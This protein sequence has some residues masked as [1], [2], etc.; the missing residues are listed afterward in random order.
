VNILIVSDFHIIEKDID[1]IESIFNE[2]CIIK[3]NNKIDK[4]I[5]AGDTFDKVNPTPKELDCFSKFVKS[6]NIPII[7]LAAQSHE[8][9]SDSISVI[10]HFGILKETIS[11][12][13]EYK[14][15]NHLFVG[16]FTLQESKYHFGSKVSKKSLENYKYV[17]LG[18]QHSLQ[19]IEPNICHVGSIRYIDF[20]E[21]QD[22]NK[23]ALLITDYKTEKQSIKIIPLVTPIHMIDLELSQ[24]LENGRSQAMP[25]LLNVAGKGKESGILGKFEALTDL[26]M[27]LNQLVSKT[28]VRVIFKDYE[29]YKE[30]LPYYEIYKQ[31][32]VLFKD[33]K[34]FIL[35]ISDNTPQSIKTETM[36]ESLI[37]FLEVNKVD[38][39]IK[40]ILEEEINA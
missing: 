37:K 25:S 16:H 28:K 2:I 38:S 26:L 36:K 6:I 23:V 22:D 34:D 21:S 35:F 31:K 18:H 15:G 20:A 27:Y 12:V 5:I 24:N 10:N 3:N 11:V 9:I 7:L 32:F 1:E 39:E 29:S 13:K 33:R 40:K 4:L 8:S 17:V 14:D 30:F 19:I